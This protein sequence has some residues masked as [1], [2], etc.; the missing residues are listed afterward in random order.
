MLVTLAVSAKLTV[1][2]LMPAA[3]TVIAPALMAGALVME[4]GALH[5]SVA[6]VPPSVVVHQNR[7]GIVSVLR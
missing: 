7:V 6:V 1:T 4:N 2:S 5:S 3:S